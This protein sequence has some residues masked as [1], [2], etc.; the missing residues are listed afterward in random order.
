MTKEE[1]AALLNGFE[2]PAREIEQHATAL[3]EAGLVAVFGQSDDLMEF[4]GAI[5]D[6]LDAYDGRKASVDSEGLLPSFHILA[7]ECDERELEAYFRRKPNVKQIEALWAP[8]D[9]DASWLI[10]TEIPHAT[11]DINE[12]GDIF[13]RGIVFALADLA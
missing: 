8:D 12:D 6:E 4:R 11:F 2:Y 1:A 9:L 3:K 10:R 13:C 5:Y 7:D